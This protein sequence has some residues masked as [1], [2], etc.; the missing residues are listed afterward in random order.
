M[1][2]LTVR[3]QDLGIGRLFEEVRDAVIVA[4][5]TTGRI[6]LWN[7]AATQIFGYS[8]SEALGLRIEA[9]VPERLQAQVSRYRETDRG[10]YDSRRLAELPAVRKGGEEISIEMSLSP[11]API[12]DAG[13]ADGRFV[14]AIVREVTERKRTLD[15][16]GESERRFATVLA[17]A[18]A[19]VYRCRNEEGYPNEFASDYALELT[20]YP[21]EDLMVGGPVRFGDLI[22]EEDRERVWEEVQGALGSRERFELRYTIRRR[23]GELRHVEEFGLLTRSSAASPDFFIGLSRSW[24]GLRS[25]STSRA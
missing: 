11:I 14:L 9:L 3:P 16:L 12:H 8:P 20:G 6:V 22:V 18:R 1:S 2:D 7:R 21:S 19:Y 24:A 10:A 17:N 5:A 13:E 15:R 25:G 4:E 23:D